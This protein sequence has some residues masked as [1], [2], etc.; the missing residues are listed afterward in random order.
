MQISSQNTHLAQKTVMFQAQTVQTYR[1]V[2][3]MSPESFPTEWAW[4]LR[5]Y[6]EG[7][8][9]PAQCQQPANQPASQL[10]SALP[11]N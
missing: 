9:G 5:T 8:V 11:A 4:I 7:I 1:N 3:T 2:L 6:L 10:A